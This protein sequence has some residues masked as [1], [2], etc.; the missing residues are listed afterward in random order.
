MM[1]ENPIELFPK[2]VGYFIRAP[3]NDAETHIEEGVRGDC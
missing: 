3:N 2:E 1:I